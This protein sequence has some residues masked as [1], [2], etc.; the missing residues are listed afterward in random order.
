M[1]SNYFHYHKPYQHS[2]IHVHLTCLCID[3]HPWRMRHISDCKQQTVFI[4]FFVYGDSFFNSFTYCTVLYIFELTKPFSLE[5]AFFCDAC[6][7]CF[8][9]AVEFQEECVLKLESQYY[10]FNQSY[11]AIEFKKIKD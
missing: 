10:E 9:F 11:W 4:F 1:A 2:S 8:C 6:T 7:F 3:I 5:E